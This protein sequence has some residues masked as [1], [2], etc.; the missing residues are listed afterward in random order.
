MM[1]NTMYMNLMFTILLHELPVLY[2]SVLLSFLG[3]FDGNA[4][5]SAGAVPFVQSFLCNFNNP[6]HATV[7]EDENAG[8]TGSYSQST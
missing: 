4:M 2:F 5:P 7:S 1:Y 3:H 6:C 8:T